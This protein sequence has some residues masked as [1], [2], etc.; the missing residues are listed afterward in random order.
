MPVTAKVGDKRMGKGKG[1]VI[2]NVFKVR[3]GF[4]LFE[5]EGHNK[6]TIIEVLSLA[7]KKLPI[8][9]KVVSI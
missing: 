9:M 1:D 5:V 4:I 8:K 3:S 6:K 2:A 7:K